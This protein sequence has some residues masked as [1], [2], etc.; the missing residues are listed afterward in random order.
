MTIYWKK[1]ENIIEEKSTEWL[2][3]EFFTD[4]V[5]NYEEKVYIKFRLCLIISKVKLFGMFLTFLAFCLINT[6]LI[7]AKVL[8]F[9]LWLTNNIT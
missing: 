8:Y 7:I 2:L 1:K 6:W 5:S 9:D 3:Q 4:K